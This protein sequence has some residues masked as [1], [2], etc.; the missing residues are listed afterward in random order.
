MSEKRN[1]GWDN[2]KPEVYNFGNLDKERLR[3][4]SKK[5]QEKSA[6]VKR[7]R[8]TARE[9][10]ENVLSLEVTDDIIA[11][12]ALPDELKERLIKNNPHATMYDLIQLVA[13]GLATG[14]DLKAVEY[15]RDTMGDKPSAKLDVTTMDIMTE[16]D[17]KLLEQVSE[18]LNDPTLI[19]AK[20][21]TEE[22]ADD[23]S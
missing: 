2:L 8:R 5:G 14:G 20:D 19:V 15:V 6:E 4:I 7:Q 16:N 3:E 17:R 23:E 10:L 12:A 21:I 22:N 9:C 13:L 18:R 1:K 11:G